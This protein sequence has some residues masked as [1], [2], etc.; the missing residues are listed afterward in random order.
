MTNR[1][2]TCNENEIFHERKKISY[3]YS[4]FQLIHQFEIYRF[5]FKNE[6]KWIEVSSMT[7]TTGGSNKNIMENKNG[8]KTS[9]NFRSVEKKL[10]I[11]EP[12]KLRFKSDG[13]PYQKFWPIQLPDA[14]HETKCQKLIRGSSSLTENQIDVVQQT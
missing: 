9:E 10:Q 1:P 2:N 14:R 6:E 5:D 13:S 4:Y 7:I 11:R 8:K 3:H 12:W